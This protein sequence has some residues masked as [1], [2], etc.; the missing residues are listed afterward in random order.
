M[1]LPQLWVV[2]AALDKMVDHLMRLEYQDEIVE[3]Q[4][5]FWIHVN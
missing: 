1:G 3:N 5:W 2:A 4:E